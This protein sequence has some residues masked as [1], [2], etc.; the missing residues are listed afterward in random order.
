MG[1][2]V[3]IHV[4]GWLSDV[5]R[6]SGNHW[7]AWNVPQ[8]LDGGITVSGYNTVH[9]QDF[10]ASEDVHVTGPQHF[11]VTGVVGSHLDISAYLYGNLDTIDTFGQGS[12]SASATTIGTLNSTFTSDNP[13]VTITS[14]SGHNYGAV[15]EPAT[16]T[17]LALGLLAMIKRKKM[18]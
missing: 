4:A 15:P 8:G 10:N 16:L 1:S 17:G 3:T 12:Y 6:V 11:D 18:A 7:P 9:V 13:D 14:A 2:T 5:T